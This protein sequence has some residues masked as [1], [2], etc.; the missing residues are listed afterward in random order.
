MK[1]FTIRE[2]VEY[3]EKI[4]AESHK[5]YALAAEMIKEPDTK[6]LAFDLA[7]EETKHFNHLRDLLN[8]SRLTSLELDIVVSQ[9]ID[10]LNRTVKT[11]E[12]TGDSDPIDILE[13]ALEREI[14]TEELYKMYLTF[15]NLPDNVV[16]VFEDLRN[17]EI[18][19]QNRIKTLIKKITGK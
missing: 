7:E 11:A 4:E 16:K 15:T 19:H 12:I 14:N 5:F 9:G 18:G 2:I 10:L 8:E 17:Q 13:V 1:D 3:A 6:N